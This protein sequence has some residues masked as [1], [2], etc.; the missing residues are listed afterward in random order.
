VTSI[1]RFL[2]RKIHDYENP[3]S[4]GS[5]LRARRVRPL[6]GLIRD[7]AGGNHG[8]VDGRVRVLDVGGTRA[9]WNAVPDELLHGN[10]LE[11]TIVNLTLEARASE[12]GFRYLQADGCDL[13]MF[14]DDSFHVA[15]SNSVIEHVGGWGRMRRF[16][17]EITRVAHS[18][19][20]QTPN[21]WFPVEPHCM[22]PLFHWLPQPTRRWLV[23]R[24]ALGHWPRAASVDEALDILEAAQLL[25]RK[26][27]ATLFPEARILTERF[28]LMPKSLIAVKGRA[29]QPRRSGPVDGKH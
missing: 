17:S 26:M 7:A 2:A 5:R 23:M 22:T 16:A 20:V 18:Y 28:L 11:V 10:R 24:F 1:S 27:M 29:S 12:D 13:S 9:Y 21:F 14:A 4:L 8:S 3:S 25:D 6:I 19:F 15:H